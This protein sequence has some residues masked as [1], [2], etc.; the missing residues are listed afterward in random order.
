MPTKRTPKPATKPT[1]ISGD[2]LLDMLPTP[3]K[4]IKKSKRIERPP[5]LDILIEGFVTSTLH[6]ARDV[7]RAT[8][9]LLQATATHDTGMVIVGDFFVAFAKVG[10]ADG[11]PVYQFTMSTLLDRVDGL[12]PVPK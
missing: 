10:E 4:K 3:A 9:E 8:S 1:H 5:D 7:R 6:N 2:D 12:V 11:V